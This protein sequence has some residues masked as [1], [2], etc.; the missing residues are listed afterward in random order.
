LRFC[1]E[2]LLVVRLLVVEIGAK[3][4]Y[5]NKVDFGSRVSK[6][7]DRPSE[8]SSVQMNKICKSFTIAINT[9]DDWMRKM[10]FILR[11]TS[12]KEYFFLPFIAAEHAEIS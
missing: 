5:I 3:Q 8:Q 10:G 2:G 7:S 9:V 12:T 1:P 4:P 11:I 6:V